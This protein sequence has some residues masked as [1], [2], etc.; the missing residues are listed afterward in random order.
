M[1]DHFAHFVRTNATM[2]VSG[3]FSWIH[4]PQK[5]FEDQYSWKCLQ[6][7]NNQPLHMY[8]AFSRAKGQ[9]VLKAENCTID[10]IELANYCVHELLLLRHSTQ[11]SG[12]HLT[13]PKCI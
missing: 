3:Y 2:K 5:I 6:N 7:R 10:L 8:W 9:T 4:C 13:R 11:A 12:S 1:E